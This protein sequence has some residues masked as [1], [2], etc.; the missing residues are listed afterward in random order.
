MKTL[1]MCVSLLLLTPTLWSQQIGSSH[2]DAAR[3]TNYSLSSYPS[4]YSSIHSVKDS[5]KEPVIS[6]HRGGRYIA[7]YPENALETFQYVA[8]QVKVIIECDVNMSSDSV[9]F[10]MHDYSLA[11]TTNGKGAVL[12]TPWSKIKS[13][14]LKDDYGIV[15][16]YHPP[17]LESTLNWSSKDYQLTLDVKRGVP[18]ERVVEMVRNYGAIDYASVITYNYESALKAYLTD[19]RIRLSVSIRNNEELQ[20]YLDGPFKTENLMAFTGLTQ[21]NPEFY[22]ALKKAGI[23]III[24]TIGNIDKSAIA[25]GD[26]VYQKIQQAGVDIL[27]TDRP[28]AVHK[29]LQNGQQQELGWEKN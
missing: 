27:A 4:L 18:I 8:R 10:L 3:L 28:L 14:N 2:V 20:R 1:L 5:F 15:T 24:G 7:G 21:R 12:E 11:R 6:A 13:L 26:K 17:T 22:E 9:L 23:T 25:K 19:P 16:R 29:A